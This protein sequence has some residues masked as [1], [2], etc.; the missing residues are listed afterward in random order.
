ME[1]RLDETLKELRRNAG[2]TQEQLACH[3][4][5]SVQAVSKWER[6]DGMPDIGLLPA[7][8]AYYDTTVDTLLGCD[9]LRRDQD[10]AEFRRQAQVLLN[11]G[12]RQERLALC[13]AMQ[14]KY[15]HDETVLNDL[16]HDLYNVDCRANGEEIIDIANRL[17]N[18]N[19]YHYGA[20]QM[21]ALT[22]SRLGN[23]QKAEE[24]ARMISPHQD[25]LRIVLKGEAL[26]EHCRWYFWKICDE[27]YLTESCLT[28]CPQA[29]YTA[30]D[31]H[32]IRRAVRDSFSLV[33][34]DG[35]FGFW[36]D[37]LARLS[38]DMAVS[39]AEMG[40]TERALDELEEMCDHLEKLEGFT[41]IDHTS[42]M[43]RGLHYEAAQVCKS[44]EQSLASSYLSQLDSHPLFRSLADHP[45]LKGIKARLEALN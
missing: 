17:L 13:R 28:Q 15:P 36:E 14:K 33:F 5:I 2:N 4:G 40:E 3:L 35:D 12:K 32:N 44:S 9:R 19:R 18:A 24:Y 20:I 8:A 45:R 7:I 10:I 30:E 39:S 31:R 26:A 42:P 25:L 11:Q 37:R 1:I 23:D 6:G 29:G 34:P 21:L 38:R 16:M 27:L 43:V 22:H 41:A